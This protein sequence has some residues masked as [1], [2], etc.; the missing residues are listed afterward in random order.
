MSQK[1]FEPY[2]F[3]FSPH[4][5]W[6]L[7]QLIDTPRAWNL[8]DDKFFVETFNDSFLPS[9]ENDNFTYEILRY[10]EQQ[11]NIKIYR[12]DLES[13]KAHT[14]P[15]PGNKTHNMVSRWKVSVRV[16]AESFIARLHDKVACRLKVQQLEKFEKLNCSLYI[17]NDYLCI[18]SEIG[19]YPLRKLNSGLLAHTVMSAICESGRVVLN[20]KNEIINPV[21]YSG[22]KI[23]SLQE[24][25]RGI[26]FNKILKQSFFTKSTANE[27]ALK[28]MPLSISRPL[29][30]YVISHFEEASEIR[31]RINS[32]NYPKRKID[33]FDSLKSLLE[34][35]SKSL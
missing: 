6:I 21:E 9:I 16:G 15:I 30:L 1:P 13:I 14:L 25:I 34:R 19:S 18:K 29:M 4:S 33:E 32:K 23:V 7:R 3:P 22:V 11:K 5:L 8:H 20:D 24:T 28:K 26:G 17:L 35:D 27:L 2:P 31:S 12:G 10:L